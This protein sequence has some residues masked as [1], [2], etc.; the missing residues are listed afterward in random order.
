MTIFST[1]PD[2]VLGGDVL[3]GN[4]WGLPGSSGQLGS[5][6]PHPVIIG[7]V[8]IDHIAKE[9]VSDI[10]HAP[11]L[12][13]LWGVIDGKNNEEKTSRMSIRHPPEFRHFLSVHMAL[14]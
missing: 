5:S 3:P 12:A 9:L 14:Q 10:E 7:H 13:I 4:Y 2:S 1:P 8:T 11:R 6:L